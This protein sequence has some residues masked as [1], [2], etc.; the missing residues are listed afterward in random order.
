MRPKE[1]RRLDV[2]KFLK[3]DIFLVL[4]VNRREEQKPLDSYQII[5]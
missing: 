4:E 1:K 5:P 2:H 3:S